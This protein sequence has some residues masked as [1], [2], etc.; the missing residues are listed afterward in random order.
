MLKIAL[1]GYGKMGKN[2]HRLALENNCQITAIVDTYG[3]NCLN[4]I[5][6]IDPKNI[7]VCIEFS[8]PDSVLENINKIAA[9]GLNMVIG[10]TGWQN[11]IDEVK[12][13]VANKNIGFIYGSNFSLG[14][15]I[16]YKITEE[17]AKIINKV[18]NY[19][20][21]GLELHHNQKL[22]SPSG[23][24]R[25]LSEIIL[26]NIDSKKTVQYDKLDRAP[27]NVEFHF[28]SVR[29]GRIPG[30]HEIG[31][32]SEADTIEL[33]HIARNRDGLALGAILAA[34]WIADKKGFYN[35]KSSFGDILNDLG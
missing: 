7:D 24:A 31:F 16:F 30:T 20:V 26:D 15:N 13:L 1:I 4:N 21:Y 5:E 17:S 32:D 12:K 8:T 27:F 34:K 11:N 3:E 29:A 28:A 22:D 19:D 25:E 9:L 23:T 35:F 2:I 10:T 33:R 6:Q 14:M 18:K